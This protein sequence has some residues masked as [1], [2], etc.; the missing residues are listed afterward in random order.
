MEVF[1]LKTALC[2]HWTQFQVDRVE[3]WSGGGGVLILGGG[4][5]SHRNI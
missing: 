3:W 5:P 2:G 1:R 4:R